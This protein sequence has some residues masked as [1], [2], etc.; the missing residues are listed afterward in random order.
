MLAGLQLSCSPL[1]HH[2]V[3]LLRSTGRLCCMVAGLRLSCSLLV[4]WLQVVLADELLNWLRC[5]PLQRL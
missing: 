4:C 1:L 3:L 5:L 2:C